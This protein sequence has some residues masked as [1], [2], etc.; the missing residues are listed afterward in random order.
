MYVGVHEYLVRLGRK[1][2]FDAKILNVVKGSKPTLNL[3]VLWKGKLQHGPYDEKYQQFDLSHT[4][5]ST[6]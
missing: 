2:P 5:G 1:L 6:F 3:P 4:R